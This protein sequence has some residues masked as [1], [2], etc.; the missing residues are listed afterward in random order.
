MQNTSRNSAK[1]NIAQLTDKGLRS[2]QRI[3]D[4]GINMIRT[5]GY[6]ETSI[7]DICT[8]VGIGIGTFYHYFRSKEEMLLALL[9][10]KTKI[11]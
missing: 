9:M 11:S 7:Q 4:I 8:E 5:R 6:S 2:Y 1:T 10:K 3:I